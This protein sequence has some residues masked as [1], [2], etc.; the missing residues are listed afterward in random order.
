MR[1]FIRMRELSNLF[2]FMSNIEF[3]N[4][5]GNP[6]SSHLPNGNISN[7]KTSLATSRLSS[8]TLDIAD[9]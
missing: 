9:E 3:H 5:N 4:S 1:F 6:H 7:E 2:W 8:C